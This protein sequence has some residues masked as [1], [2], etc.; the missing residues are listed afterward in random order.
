M[1]KKRYAYTEATDLTGLSFTMTSYGYEE[2]VVD[3]MYTVNNWNDLL[4]SYNGNPI[5]YD[6]IGNPDF[7][8]GYTL[9][10][11]GRRLTRIPD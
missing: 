11:E 8:N 6:E 5:T 4:T 2:D 3:V 9:E 7:Y 1:S 10:W